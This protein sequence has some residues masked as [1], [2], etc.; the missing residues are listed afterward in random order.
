MNDDILPLPPI[1]SYNEILFFK[2]IRNKTIFKHI[3]S[4]LWEKSELNMD[5]LTMVEKNEYS[6]ILNK[7]KSNTPIIVDEKSIEVLCENYIYNPYFE[8]MFDLL[9][10]QYGDKLKKLNILESIAGQQNQHY[11][12]D[13]FKFVYKYFNNSNQTHKIFT[14]LD[15]C[16]EC[17]KPNYKI[18]KH[19]IHTLKNSLI[20][21]SIGDYKVPIFTL[22]NVSGFFKDAKKKINL[23]KE[24]LNIDIKQ[25][26]KKL[27]EKENQILPYLVNRTATE[28]AVKENGFIDEEALELYLITVKT[29]KC[30]TTF[31]N[32]DMFFLNH[33]NFLLLYLLREELDNQTFKMNLLNNLE[34]FNNDTSLL[35]SAAKE[36]LIKNNQ[37]CKILRY[38]GFYIVNELLQQ[39]NFNELDEYIDEYLSK[40][41]NDEQLG[42]LINF[43]FQYSIVHFSI[44]T[45]NYYMKY[46]EQ[47]HGED[48]HNYLIGDPIQ[49]HYYEKEKLNQINKSNII[50]FLEDLVS[51]FNNGFTSNNYL[52]AALSLIIKNHNGEILELIFNS[53]SG[54]GAIKEVYIDMLSSE[55]Q[56][57]VNNHFESAK[58]DIME[59]D[60]K[61]M[62]I[63]IDHFDTIEHITIDENFQIEIS[64]KHYGKFLNFYFQ[65][66][67]GN[68]F[69]EF[70]SFIIICFIKSRF[71]SIEQSIDIYNSI[72]KNNLLVYSKKEFLHSSILLENLLKSIKKQD[73][74]SI[75]KILA[76]VYNHNNNYINNN[77]NNNND[78]KLPDS[79]NNSLEIIN[80]LSSK[81]YLNHFK[82]KYILKWIDKHINNVPKEFIF[83]LIPS[84]NTDLINYFNEKYYNTITIKFHIDQSL[85]LENICDSSEK[86]H[87]NEIVNIQNS[88][89]AIKALYHCFYEPAYKYINNSLDKFVE[90]FKSLSKEQ[91]FLNNVFKLSL[92]SAPYHWVIKFDQIYKKIMKKSIYLDYIFNYS[93]YKEIEH[94]WN[95]RIEDR[96]ILLN[97]IFGMEYGNPLYLKDPDDFYNKIPLIEYLLEKK[98]E[99]L[100]DYFKKHRVKFSE[101]LFL[102]RFIIYGNIKIFNQLK[103]IFI[104][105]DQYLEIALDFPL[106]LSFC[107]LKY[108]HFCEI[109]EFLHTNQ[110]LSKKN[111]NFK[112]YN[113]V[114]S[115]EDYSSHG[116]GREVINS[117]LVLKSVVALINT[118]RPI[119][120]K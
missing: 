47:F 107:E 80:Y 78:F 70:D 84:N 43:I 66:A 82:L 59:L 51:K 96:D 76:A 69:T 33:F 20:N 104:I 28:V 71:S 38:M 99:F 73:I 5:L 24:C 36:Y 102:Y 64:N 35:L 30:Y 19:I 3:L 87:Y 86:I 117:F 56:I 41:S 94:L 40:Y 12:L 98:K 8:E 14:L 6:I 91:N 115:I 60:F 103:S 26:T 31:I 77:N 75:N 72:D 7:L 74:G 52:K 101:K 93:N 97:Y 62:K 21:T 18:L 90:D 34:S 106:M 63:F 67:F 83:N 48:F 100:I 110:L 2:I 27:L 22:F 114:D 53:F 120:D 29:G 118:L 105:I 81:G 46:I 10:K 68:L 57:L 109:L 16:L 45:L 11:S 50:L 42:L 65:Y 32:P 89:N 23:F 13:L 1:V 85:G 61:K 4:F 119:E 108:I 9:W 55:T 54:N 95:N 37:E 15:L 25:E 49:Q 58:N 116:G 111:I 113:F 88:K 17:E 79:F 44:E 39:R 112:N 92:V